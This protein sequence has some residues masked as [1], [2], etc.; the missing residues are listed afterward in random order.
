MLSL[1][2]PSVVAKRRSHD[3]QIL[4]CLQGFGKRRARTTNLSAL[5]TPEPKPGLCVDNG[6]RGG[7]V[8]LQGVEDDA[9]DRPDS[10]S[11]SCN[12]SIKPRWRE[13]FEDNHSVLECRF[14]SSKQYV[15]PSNHDA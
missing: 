5:Q 12:K 11:G 7:E 2:V 15:L 3:H 13:R 1:G 9:W 10:Q 6:F 14:H 8:Q 4:Q